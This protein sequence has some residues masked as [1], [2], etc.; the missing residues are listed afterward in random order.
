[1]KNTF[2]S[3]SS[4][5]LIIF[6]TYIFKACCFFLFLTLGSSLNAQT[7][8]WRGIFSTDWDV[9]SNWS[10]SG[11]PGSND[12]VLIEDGIQFDPVIDANISVK[13][14]EIAAAGRLTIDSGVSLNVDGATGVGLLN[15][16]QLDNSGTINIGQ[17]SAV[18]GSGIENTGTLN[19]SNIID[20]DD[21]G[22]IGIYNNGG[23]MF[24]S[25]GIVR[26]DNTTGTG[27][28]NTTGSTL[29]IKD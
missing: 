15:K 17:N 28:E 5:G 3:L 18:G 25:N 1:M 4:K 19:N 21:T 2:S 14:I 26:I 20:I 29:T 6:N 11:V 12:N 22:S 27:L 16:G 24:I 7:K 8:T 23:T 9:S 13:S 10:P